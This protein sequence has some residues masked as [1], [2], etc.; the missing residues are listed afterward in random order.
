MI[1]KRR[2]P[3]DLGFKTNE[4]TKTADLHVANVPAWFSFTFDT[5]AK[6]KNTPFSSIVA[7]R[8]MV[9]ELDNNA[10]TNDGRPYRH[11]VNDG[12]HDHP[13]HLGKNNSTGFTK[14]AVSASAGGD[15]Y[16]D[17][18]L[19]SDGSVFLRVPAGKPL[20]FQGID[21]KGHVVVQ[22]SRL[23]TLPPGPQTV[24][25]SVRSDQYASQCS[26]CHGTL[27]GK[28]FVGLKG[29]AN[30]PLAPL[31]FET[32]AAKLAPIDASSA[33]AKKLTFV[34]T[35]RPILDKKCV[36]CHSGA[37]PAGELSLEAKYSQTGNYP[38]G[39][40]AK[41]PLADGAYLSTIPVDKRVPAYNY[42]VAF[43]WAMREDEAPYKQAYA[44]QMAS[45]EPLAGL[46]PWDPAYQNLFAHD[47]K[48]F[49]YLGGYFTPNF[50]RSDRLGGV[51]KDSFL[52]E[53]LSGRDLDPTRAPGA[54]SHSGFLTE[55]E[56]RDIISVIDVGF[57]YMATCDG[58]M[59]PSGPNAGKPWG[60]IRTLP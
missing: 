55:A 33:T 49:I 42:S 25:T 45:Y 11:A 50:G 39:K 60:D 13:T 24:H 8:V 28:P 14:L 23:F 22:R 16:G 51:A 36:G 19:K 56:V 7:L 2:A 41:A 26:S 17:V 9:K 52:V 47:D 31:D 29:T 20:F 43:A 37:T 30:I 46:A 12:A 3:R 27:D 34:D 48:R 35:I 6:V 38:A 21:A 44:A 10:C 57:P 15:A 59:V 4:A 1:G 18:P 5:A 40:W 32:L 53:L 54:T 58:K